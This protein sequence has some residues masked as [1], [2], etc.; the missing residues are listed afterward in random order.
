MNAIGAARIEPT[1]QPFTVAVFGLGFVGLPLSLSCCLHGCRVWGVDVAPDLVRDLEQ[2][3]TYLAESHQGHSTQE[4][5]QEQLAAGR[6]RPT[7]DA[8]AALAAC[9][10][11]FITVGVPMAGGR[12][13][14][15]PLEA[16]CRTVGQ[17]LRPGQLVVLR[18]T[19]PPGTTDQ[20]L[21]P[22]LEQAS[23]LQ[24]GRDF[25]LA[26]AP[27]RMAEG[28]AFTDFA[29][30]PSLVAGVDEASR[31]RASAALHQVT[32]APLVPA[33]SI[34]VAELSKVVENVQR[35]VNIAM[36]QQF[37]R[38][39]EGLGV[40]TQELI[41]LANTHR[42]VRLL[43]PG[44]GVGGYCLPNALAYLEPA[45]EA[46]GADISLM[47]LARQVN[48]AVPG[49]VCDLTAQALG[50][51]GRSLASSRVAVLGLAMKDYTGDDRYSPPIA[52]CEQLLAR[53]VRVAAYDPLVVAEYPFKLTALE[54]CLRGADA[55]LIL[56]RQQAFEGPDLLP[57]IQRLAPGAVLVDT[58]F[59]VDPGAARAAG[60]RLLRI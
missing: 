39:C 3:I 8:A 50:E 46:A 2:G 17:G 45:A 27:E 52:V 47:R 42:T 22:I 51:A 13:V 29:E 43:Q 60:L 38:V 33:S 40:D 15:G 28:R 41:T 10:T 44:P 21:R 12:H 48:D 53:G 59:V 26:Y 58:R 14:Y 37:A 1:P 34:L 9:D 36:V 49:V 20:R 25:H 19:L 4:V 56:T 23:G 31:D 16:V 35:D 54:P 6:F 7:L 11:I 30:V 18:P 24:A 55:V 5:L 32:R 57:A